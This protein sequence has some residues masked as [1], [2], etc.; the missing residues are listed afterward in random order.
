MM[1]TATRNYLILKITI[2]KIIKKISNI[3]KNNNQNNKNNLI[4]VSKR[5]K[6][7]YQLIM[8]YR[9]YSLR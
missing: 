8:I 2:K 5:V 9:S 1:Y 3:A 4:K 7:S 6:I